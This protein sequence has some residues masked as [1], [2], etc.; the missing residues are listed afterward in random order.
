M[1]NSVTHASEMASGAKGSLYHSTHVN[2]WL[3]AEIDHG[4]PHLSTRYDHP[5]LEEIIAL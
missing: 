4:S 2:E 5:E 1:G 3:S